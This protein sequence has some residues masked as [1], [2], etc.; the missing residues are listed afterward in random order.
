MDLVEA[1]EESIHLPRLL[2]TTLQERETFTYL[3]TGEVR[4]EAD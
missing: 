4:R 2:E 3:P 1:I